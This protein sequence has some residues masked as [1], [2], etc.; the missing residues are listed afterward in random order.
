[1]WFKK[2]QQHFSKTLK[3]FSLNLDGYVLFLIK[4][5]CLPF[6]LEV[7]GSR[8][9]RC[10]FLWQPGHGS[11]SFTVCVY[12]QSCLTLCDPMDCS[13]PG[14]SIYEILQARVQEW[15]AISSSNSFT[16]AEAI[17]MVSRSYNIGVQ[18]DRQWYP[19]Q[20][21]DF[22]LSIEWFATFF[23]A[24]TIILL[25]APESVHHHGS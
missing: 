13:P 6:V 25:V 12:A 15:V 17:G 22:R 14:S 2:Q 4:L 20:N 23:T 16:E 9:F 24:Q 19:A 21:F 10:L 7:W 8:C 11:S 5:Y 3:N 1:M 18:Q